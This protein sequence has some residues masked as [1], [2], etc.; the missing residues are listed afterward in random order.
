MNYQLFKLIQTL[1]LRYIFVYT[2]TFKASIKSN[3]LLKKSTRIPTRDICV[4]IALKIEAYTLVKIL[5][6]DKQRQYTNKVMNTT[7]KDNY[8]IEDTNVNHICTYCLIPKEIYLIMLL[9]ITFFP[10]C[11]HYKKK[12][13]SIDYYIAN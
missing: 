5:C 11:L 12:L 6:T 9:Y 3:Y 10:F 8:S 2:S 1:F 13:R 4:H 7:Y